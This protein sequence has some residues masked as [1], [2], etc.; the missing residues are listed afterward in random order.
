MEEETDRF[1]FTGER[2]GDD[3]DAHFSQPSGTFVI[4]RLHLLSSEDFLFVD[5]LN[6]EYKLRLTADSLPAVQTLQSFIGT[7]FLGMHLTI[8]PLKPS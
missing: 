1:P 4:C 8:Q 3:A 2:R 5:F 6:F 7:L